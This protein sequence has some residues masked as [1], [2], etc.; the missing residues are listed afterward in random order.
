MGEGRV[1][2]PYAGVVVHVEKEKLE[3]GLFLIRI[4][5]IEYVLKLQVQLRK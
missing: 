1:R 3:I 2:G 5:V 4:R